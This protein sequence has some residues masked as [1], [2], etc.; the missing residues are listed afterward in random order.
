LYGGRWNSVGKSCIYLASSESL[1]ILEI[2]VHLNNSKTIAEYELYSVEF[3]AKDT[4]FLSADN[5]PDNW[6]ED[7]APQET[8]EIGDDWL[9]RNESVALSIPSTIVVREQNYIINISHP[10]FEEMLKTIKQLEFSMD[11]R[12]A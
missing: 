12:L 7:P 3:Y 4:M 5:L 9:S 6:Q 2:L 10:Q 8:A 11:K 1:A